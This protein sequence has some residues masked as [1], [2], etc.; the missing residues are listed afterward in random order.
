MFTTKVSGVSHGHRRPSATMADRTM[1]EA[2]PGG[3]FRVPPQWCR[4]VLILGER[5]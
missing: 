5:V 1:D 4:A 3:R 2:R